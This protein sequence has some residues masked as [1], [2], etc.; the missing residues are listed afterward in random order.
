MTSANTPPNTPQIE[1]R[2]RDVFPGRDEFPA[3]TKEFV[4][5]VTALCRDM[6]RALIKLDK[7]GKN[8]E[9][10]APLRNE[11]PDKEYVRFVVVSFFFQLLFLFFH[12]SSVL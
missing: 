5:P 4:C 8:K 12:V 10:F 6:M 3:Y 11:V 9:Y 2:T 1:F 7:N